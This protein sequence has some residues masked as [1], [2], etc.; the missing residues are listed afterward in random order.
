MPEIYITDTQAALAMH[1]HGGEFMKRLAECWMA[2]DPMNRARLKEA[3]RPEFDRYRARAA[4]DVQV[5]QAGAV[6]D[7]EKAHK[8]Y[9]ALAREAA[10]R[11]GEDVLP[12]H[13]E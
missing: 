9:T 11:T 6:P 8:H 13:R 7:M 4:M 1:S 10:E 12:E 2:G 3:F 5:A